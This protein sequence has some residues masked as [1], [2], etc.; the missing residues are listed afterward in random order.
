MR[1]LE[2]SLLPGRFAISRLDPSAR[3][4]AWAQSG[5]F[6]SVTRTAE[7]LS[8]VSPE[9]AVPPGTAARGG[10]K[11]WRVAGTLDFS[12]TGVLASIAEPLARAGVSIF[13]VSTFDTDYILVP[14][15]RVADAATALSAAGHRVLNGAP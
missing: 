4:P 12:L 11:A 9:D 15:A 14:E 7:E 3:I 5:S 2:L 6:L 1:P 10:W 8:I 13:A